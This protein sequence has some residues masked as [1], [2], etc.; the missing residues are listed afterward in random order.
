MFPQHWVV[1]CLCFAGS[2]LLRVLFSHWVVFVFLF[3]SVFCFHWKP[4]VA[5]PTLYKEVRRRANQLLCRSKPVWGTHGRSLYRHVGRP[6]SVPFYI[7]HAFSFVVVWGLTLLYIIS[8]IS[9]IAKTCTCYHIFTRWGGDD[10]KIF[11]WMGTHSNFPI[12]NVKS[13]L[14][15]LLQAQ[16]CKALLSSQ[17]GRVLTQLNV[18]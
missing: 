9:W 11:L 15:G 3:C 14:Q 10:Q 6:L 2:W 12:L 18:F 13:D 4:P 5:A 8:S 7:S 16:P 1:L 17:T